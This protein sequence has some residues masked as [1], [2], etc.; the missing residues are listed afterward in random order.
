MVPVVIRCIRGCDPQTGGMSPA[1]T[2]ELCP[3]E[4]SHSYT[5]DT[6][7]NPLISPACGTHG[8]QHKSIKGVLFILFIHVKHYILKAMFWIPYFN[9]HGG[10]LTYSAESTLNGNIIMLPIISL[11]WWV[12][13]FYII[14]FRKALRSCDGLLPSHHWLAWFH[15]IN[16]ILYC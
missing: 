15:F 8:G 3:E 5:E 12:I 7:Q 6:V 14:C 9:G 10:L 16:T 13:K 11:M 2:S 4:C 1:G